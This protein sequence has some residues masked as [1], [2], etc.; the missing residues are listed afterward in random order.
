ME[1]LSEWGWG[2]VF[3][4]LERKDRKKD[5]QRT[6]GQADPEVKIV[7]NITCVLKYTM[8]ILHSK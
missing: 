1:V 6:Y 3:A 8:D 4:N 7:V 2:L 5:E